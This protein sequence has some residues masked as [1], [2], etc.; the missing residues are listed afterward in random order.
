MIENSVKKACSTKYTWYNF[1][2]LLKSD[3][4]K[5]RFGGQVIV[6]NRFLSRLNNRPIHI[7]LFQGM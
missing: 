5:T 4:L 6:L 1:C 3:L 7:K 2:L